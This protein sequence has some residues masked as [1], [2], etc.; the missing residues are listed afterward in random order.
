MGERPSLGIRAASPVQQLLSHP[1]SPCLSFP[2]L[3]MGQLRHR[4]GVT[5][6]AV[7]H[8]RGEWQPKPYGGLAGPGAFPQ[9]SVP[10]SPSRCPLQQELCGTSCAV[11]TRRSMLATR[12]PVWSL[13]SSPLALRC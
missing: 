9:R 3:Q 6:P 1:T 5:G 10:L 11:A 4:D 12:P 2:N 8:R 7:S 13:L